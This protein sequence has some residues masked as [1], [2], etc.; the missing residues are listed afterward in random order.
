MELYFLGRV[1]RDL[2]PLAAFS[3]W[4]I[5]VPRVLYPLPFLDLFVFEPP[6][7]LLQGVKRG[8]IKRWLKGTRGLLTCIRS[9]YFLEYNHSLAFVSFFNLCRSGSMVKSAS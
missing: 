3:Y 1:V 6:N 4:P 7:P 9:V 8:K 2:L 5:E